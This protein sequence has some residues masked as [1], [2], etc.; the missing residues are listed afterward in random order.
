[1]TMT[2]LVLASESDRTADGVVSGLTERGFSVMRL[3]LS[4]S[5]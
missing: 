1:M 3:D 4:Y 5:D 2:V